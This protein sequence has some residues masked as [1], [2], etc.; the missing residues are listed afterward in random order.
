RHTRSKRDWSSDVCSS[1]LTEDEI[2]W[3]HAYVKWMSFVNDFKNLGGLVTAGSDS[4]FIYKVFGFGLIEEL[5]LLLEAGFHPLEV[6]RARSEERRV[7][8]DQRPRTG[9]L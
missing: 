5:E 1:D 8:Q 9:L 7:G 3:R 2:A 4:G 6:V